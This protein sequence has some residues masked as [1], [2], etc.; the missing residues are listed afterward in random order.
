MAEK[1]VGLERYS[2]DKDLLSVLPVANE[3]LINSKVVSSLSIF[4]LSLK[5]FAGTVRKLCN[6]RVST[7]RLRLS[8]G[9]RLR[10]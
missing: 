7:N 4:R 9:R 6:V 10:S 2:L 5:A 8:H 1:I 3:A